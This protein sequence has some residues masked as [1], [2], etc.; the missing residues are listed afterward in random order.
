VVND[1]RRARL[2]A[3]LVAAAILLAARSSPAH[4]L[5]NFS[6]SH[7]AG[8]RVEETAIHVRYLIDMAEIPT[9]QEGQ[10]TGITPQAGPASLDGYLTRQAQVLANGLRL[11]LDGRRLRLEAESREAIFPPGAGGLPTMKLGIVY[12]AR[13]DEPA[14]GRFSSLYY[15]DDNFP[16]RA[17]WKEI[18]AGAGPGMALAQSSAPENDR[19]RE[20]A[21]YPT[22]LLNSPPQDLEAHIVFGASP[23]ARAPAARPA[24]L[25]SG[26]DPGSARGVT[27]AREA[28]SPRAVA[29]P[30]T[31][32]H[33][34]VGLEANRQATPRSAFT[35]LVS[36]KELRL[37]IVL[38]AVVVAAGLGALHALEPGHGKT[39]VGAYLVGSRGS[40]WHAVVLGTIVTASHTAGVYLLG[41]VTLYASRY[42]VPERIYPWLGVFS[43]LT[44]AVLG[45]VLVRRRYRGHE[46]PHSHHHHH[47]HGGSHDHHH[48][49]SHGHDGDP[50]GHWHSHAHGGH[51]HHRHGSDGATP[52][53][54][55]LALGV[56]GGIVPCPAA[57]VVLLSTIALGRVGFGLLLIVAFS[58]GLAA[59]LIAIGLLIVHARRFM[60]RFDGGGTLVTRWLPLTSAAMIT[61]LGVGM[62]VQALLTA[63]ILPPRLS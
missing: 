18:V 30:R 59:V 32:A 28:L 42:V 22:D 23:V 8:I 55:L 52:L 2:A 38:F 10:E 20:L 3:G 12:R 1:R 53:R 61:L 49:H 16:G 31:S 58:M 48:G 62:A 6:I 27:I 54:E 29:T 50:E 14:R 51:G 41:G 21:D 7:Y 35:E 43:G 37:G 11:E 47:A 25:R 4:P 56:S 60:A 19:S 9:F 17:G 57:L 34:R 39:V 46:H 45:L 13:L 36:A 33:E 40:A 63:G 5:G 15:R 44:I 24:P 26:V